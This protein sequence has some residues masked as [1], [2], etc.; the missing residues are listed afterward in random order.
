MGK[1][2][3]TPKQLPHRRYD[4]FKETIRVQNVGTNF[5]PRAITVEEMRGFIYVT[6]GPCICIFSTNCDL[7]TTFHCPHMV[8]I[9]GVAI[10]QYGIYVSDMC[11]DII[12]HIKEHMG[13]I[14]TIV[15]SGT[16]FY[17]LA[18]LEPE[19]YLA[20][21][22]NNMVTVLSSDT[23]ENIRHITCATLNHPV[24]VKL[25]HSELYVLSENGDP[26]MHVFT[27]SGTLLDYLN[28][29]IETLHQTIFG[30]YY[31]CLDSNCNILVTDISS[32]AIVIYSKR[33]VELHTIRSDCTSEYLLGISV[34]CPSRFVVGL[35]D[36]LII[37]SLQ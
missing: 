36:K 8:S 6:N 18:I 30:T 2:H 35:R 21:K 12:L 33:G 7:I 25:S 26:R 23:L 34:L 15:K 29:R 14:Q 11:A 20:D 31:F 27:H 28:T 9:H 32:H 24:D 16:L 17:N 3:S 5:H 13:S 10:H 4:L 19:L 1:R 22:Y 37:Y